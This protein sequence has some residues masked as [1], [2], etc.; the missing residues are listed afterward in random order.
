MSGNMIGFIIW[1]IVALIIIGMGINACFSKKE[2]AFGFWA[3]IKQFPVKDIR[4]YN[5]ATGKLFI[6]YG[7]I[8]IVL[9]LPLLKGQNNPYILLSVLGVMIETIAIM[10]IYGMCVEA[11]YKE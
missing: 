11:K 9:E 4:G 3:N 10:V 6:I 2:V 5:R 1:V 7:L 8:L